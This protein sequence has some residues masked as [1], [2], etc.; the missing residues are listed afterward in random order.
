MEMVQNVGMVPKFP[1]VPTTINV[2]FCSGIKVLCQVKASLPYHQKRPFY[3]IAHRANQPSWALKAFQNGANAIEID[4]H[5]HSGKRKFC[6]DHDGP[7]HCAHWL[8]DRCELCSILED[9]F[10]KTDR[11]VLVF[12]KSHFR[13]RVVVFTF[14]FLIMIAHGCPII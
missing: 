8:S 11:R 1:N 12:N 10:W 13:A 14:V 7:G 9:C 2:F 3:V 5:Y 4:L 6:V